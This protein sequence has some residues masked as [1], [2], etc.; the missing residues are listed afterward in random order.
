[1]DLKKLITFLFVI[2]ITLLSAKDTTTM[3]E[4]Q[5]FPK[6][7]AETLSGVDMTFPD[8]LTGKATIILLAFKRETQKVIDSW[9]KPFIKEFEDN[10]EVQ[11]FEIP[12]LSRYWIVM[13]PI[14]DGGMRSG[15]LK[16]NHKNV[17]TFYGDVDKYCKLLSIEDK[18]D[19]YVFLLDSEGVIQ[20]RDNGFATE[21]KLNQLF[22]QTRKLT[23]K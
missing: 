11:F 2:N 12:M 15:I 14:I 21:Q 3:T 19:G 18:S 16:Q 13:S 10:D 1:M 5:V 20:W 8:D 9:L 7:R 4:K 22:E 23:N 6:L 17:A